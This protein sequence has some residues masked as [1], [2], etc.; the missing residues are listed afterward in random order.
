MANSV[1]FWLNS[2]IVTWQS[3]LV[4]CSIPCNCLYRNGDVLY[5][6]CCSGKSLWASFTAHV[7]NNLL[8][9]IVGIW[10][11]VSTSSSMMWRSLTGTLLGMGISAG[12]VYWRLLKNK[13]EKISKD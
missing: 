2:P 8:I 7:V 1:Y 11:A 6:N 12:L 13:R 10:A 5:A 3:G 4:Q 9:Y